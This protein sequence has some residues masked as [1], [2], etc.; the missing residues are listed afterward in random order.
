MNGLIAFWA[1]NSV[2]AN[3]LMLVALVGGVIGYSRLEKETFPAVNFNGVEINITW[4]GASPQEVEEQLIVRMEEAIADIDGMEELTSISREGSGTVLINTKNSTDTAVF[5]DEV[6]SRVDA[7]NNLPDSAYEPQVL[8]WRETQPYGGIVLSGDIDLRELKREAEKLRDRL[9]Q[10]PGGELAEVNGILG[11]EVT[12]EVSEDAM[13][14]YGLTFDSVA[15][16]IRSASVN[17]SGG[18]VRT[19]TGSVSLQTRAL[20]DTQA[21]FE[22]LIIRQTANGGVV[23]LDDVA[24]VEDGF[25]DA[26]LDAR[27]NKRAAA[28]IF[29]PQTEVMDLPAYSRAIQEF[30]E[31]ENE[32][33]PGTLELDILWD[34]HD[35]FSALMNIIGNSAVIG[36]TMV[37]IL[38]ILFLR[39]IVAFWVAVGIVTAFAGG[40]ALLPFLGVSL[41]ILSLFGCLLVIGVVVDDAI[42][43]GENIHGEVER[44]KNQGLQAA[45]S[46]AT[47]V[48]KPVVF[49]VI[50]TMI[51]FAP[52]ALISGPER[53]FTQNLTITVIAALTFSLIEAFLILPNHLSHLKPQKFDGMGGKFARFQSRI[54]DS[55]L[56]VADNVYKPILEA[57][58]KFR[59]ATASFFIALFILAVSLMQHGY[60]VMKIMPE[61][62]GDLIFVNI[63]MPNGSPFSRTMDVRD[64]L[65]LGVDKLREDL[66]EEYPNADE[67]VIQGASIIAYN[68]FIEAYVDLS[69]PETRPRDISTK[70]LAS[71]LRELTGPIPDAEEVTFDFTFNRQ[72]DRIRF[73]LN[74]PDLD[75][76]QAAAGDLKAK[77][78]TYADA[79]D[80]GDN[81]SAAGE[82]IRLSLKP[83]AEA[84]GLTLGEVSRQVR[85]AYYGEEVQRLPREGD[86]VRVMVKLPEDAR[87]SLDS[88]REFRIRTNDGRQIPMFEVVD[89]TYAPGVNV[90]LRNERQRSIAVFAQI[91]GDE[92]QRITNDIEESYLPELRDRYPGLETSE[93]GAGER[94]EAFISEAM[95][96]QVVAIVVMYIVLAVAFGSYWQPLLIMTAIPFA[97]AGAVFGHLFFGIPMALF[98]VFGV[99]AAAGVV[100]NDNLVLV[101]YLNKCRRSGAGAVQAVVEAGVMR[102]RPVLLTS[103]TTFVGILPMIADRSVQAQ[104]LKPMVVSLGC[105]VVFALF[106]SLLLVP[107]L[108]AIGVEIKRYFDWMLRGTP[109]RPIGGT[110]DESTTLHAGGSAGDLPPATQPAE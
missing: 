80:I 91:N 18:S 96:L 49:G 108:Y 7:I 65:D 62:E 97:V 23:R 30:V 105:A 64:A 22:N 28:F 86:D 1:R 48:S 66:Q 9:S 24:I 4:P 79:Y 110:Y 69:P 71:R 43:I 42:I 106:I 107:A 53:Q 12:I 46:G 59:Y 13:R 57:A 58:V 19:Q 5:M 15:N 98:S 72:D 36:T 75:V 10:I 101:D 51:A 85:Q 95:I 56:W 88:L 40:F 81:L 2:A 78:A 17:G 102:F 39:P 55:L 82:E 20:A 104:F 70:Q 83:G 21:Q 73:A 94:E 74:H 44:G 47:A 25:V 50:T 6:K 33:L 68:R 103:L 41:N 84:L 31:A 35:F 26:D 67:D 37:L 63:E 16:A 89:I 54:A 8:R 3:L 61:I 27:F 109:F 32:K 45:I 14:R 93:S 38:L 29:L 99:A 87:R 90:I 11:E 60:V 77:L 100:I 76:L 52:W 92:R 34:D